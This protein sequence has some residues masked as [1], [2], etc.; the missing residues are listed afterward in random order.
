M[1]GIASK[2]ALE[3]TLP[4]YQLVIETFGTDRSHES[5]G[6][7]VGIRGPIRGLEDLATDGT[8]HLVEALHVL[9]VTVSEEEFDPDSGIVKVGR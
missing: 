8:E 5:L 4:H 7:G 2:D 1:T 3:V 6:M 9:G